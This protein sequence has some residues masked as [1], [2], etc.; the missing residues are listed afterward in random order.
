MG[1]VQMT[2]MLI[3]KGANPSSTNSAGIPALTIAILKMD[4]LGAEEIVALLLGHGARVNQQGGGDRSSP[5]HAA[6]MTGNVKCAE[7]LLASGADPQLPNGDG[8][9]PLQ[10]AERKNNA[11]LIALLRG[12]AAR[13]VP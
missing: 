9:T 5:L 10:F 7:K 1:N 2:K 3:E 11:A 6:V 4:G 8:N 12:S 13:P